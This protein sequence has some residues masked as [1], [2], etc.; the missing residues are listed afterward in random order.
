ELRLVAHLD[1]EEEERRRP[2]DASGAKLLVLLLEAIGDQRPA[3]HGDE[4]D[5]EDPA[6]AVRPDGPHEPR[7]DGTGRRMI[8]KGRREDSRDDGPRALETRG[9][10]EREERGLVADRGDGDDSSRDQQRLERQ[11]RATPPRPRA[12]S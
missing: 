12:R 2:E 6:H 11:A 10:A 4:G 7:A 3:G 8:E 5:G 1:E 9:G